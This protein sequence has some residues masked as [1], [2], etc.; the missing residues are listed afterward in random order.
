MYEVKPQ[1]FQ[2]VPSAILIIMGLMDCATTAIGV[3]YAGA[4][5]ANPCLA[6]V[7]STNIYLFVVLKIAATFLIG[8]TYM[9]AKKTLNGCSNKNSRPFKLSKHIINISYIGIFTFLSI[10]V[11]NNFAVIMT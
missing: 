11:I 3:L 5:E 10:V 6:G 4:V 8:F 7:V 9:F 2:A 1:L